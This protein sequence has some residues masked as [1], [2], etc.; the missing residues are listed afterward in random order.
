MNVNDSG[1]CD[2]ITTRKVLAFKFC[3]KLNAEEMGRQQYYFH[4]PEYAMHVH[5]KPYGV[6]V[7]HLLD[8]LNVFT[9]PESRKTSTEKHSL[10]YKFPV[11]SLLRRVSRVSG[12]YSLGTLAWDKM[13]N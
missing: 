3:P 5:D 2:R 4:T 12:V 8:C 11:L 1:V 13:F 7:R 9:P 10:I 6:N